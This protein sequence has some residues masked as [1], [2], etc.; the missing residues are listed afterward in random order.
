MTAEKISLDIDIFSEVFLY[1]YTRKPTLYMDIYVLNLMGSNRTFMEL[2]SRKGGE[3]ITLKTC[4]NRT[5]MEL[6]FT[7]NGNSVCQ[8]R[9]F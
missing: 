9:L 4:S 3:T 7:R 6:K 8:I 5:F 2:K 1:L